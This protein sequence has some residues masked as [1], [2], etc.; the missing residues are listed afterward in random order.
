MI[1]P[2]GV[3]VLKEYQSDK[4][5]DFDMKKIICITLLIVLIFSGCSLKKGNTPE[6]VADSSAQS[7][8][9][10]EIK[11]G[12][13]PVD[14]LNPLM[15]RHASICDF[16]ELI[17]EGLFEVMPDHSAVPVLASDYIASENNTVY[18]I[19]LKSV[20]KFHGS[21]PFGSDDVVA[22]LDYIKMYGG[23]Y[24]SIISNMLSYEAPSDESVVIKLLNPVADFINLLDFPILP[25]GLA[26]EDF[27]EYS[28]SFV[29]NGTG[30][31][32]FDGKQDYKNIYLKVNNY[33]HESDKK[34]HIEK[35]NIEILSDEETVISAFD[36]G[37]I[38]VLTT[39]WKPASEMNLTS[40]EH[41]VF[42][43]E[44]NRYTFVGMNPGGAMLDT[45]SER[46]ELI[47]SIDVKT[48]TQDI[49]LGG[50]V[51]AY[52][53]LREGVYFN[54]KNK[55]EDGDNKKAEKDSSKQEDDKDSKK[56]EDFVEIK[57]KNFENP[58]Y[59]LYNSESKTKERLAMALKQQLESKGYPVTLDPQTYTNYLSK[60]AG[61]AYDLYIGEVSIDNSGNLEFMF[62]LNRSWQNICI[63][64]TPEL[65]TL[66]SN[67]NRMTDKESRMVAWENFKKYYSDNAFQIPLYFTNSSLMVGKRIKGSAEPNLSSLLAGF[68]NL[69]IEK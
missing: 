66:I 2:A 27:L 65:A 53:P 20:V 3:S 18:T 44:Q 40:S 58:L 54:E 51:E 14:T 35:V 52:F 62:G 9:G 4:K 49:M 22:T 7:V 41:N 45:V 23:K 24:A 63:F 1:T 21:Q 5:G 43:T 15:S 42:D 17:Y 46:R 61:C 34:P 31:Y 55:N 12:C 32:L 39:S 69:Y 47:S 16:L 25:A 30:M 38:D 36:A 33:W 19:K 64:S 28:S 37:A 10:G 57:E 48:I 56:E 68:E 26:P 29:P 11:L 67:L 59:L 13:V 6:K 50:A 60:I 8:D